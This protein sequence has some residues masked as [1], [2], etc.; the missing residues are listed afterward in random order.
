M[1]LLKKN[2]WLLFI[3][4][5]ISGF[6]LLASLS[7]IRWQELVDHYTQSQ[8]ASTQHWY[9]SFTSIIQQ[10]EGI[11]TLLGEE[12][13]VLQQTNPEE[14]RAELDNLMTLNLDIFSGFA[15]ISAEGDVIEVTSNLA[16]PTYPQLLEVAETKDSFEY[17]LMT[18]KMVLGRS[19]FAPRLVIPARKTIYDDNGD[20]LGVMTG[21]LKLDGNKGFFGAGHVLGDFNRITVLRNRDHYIQY[22]SSKKML[23]DFHKE[24]LSELA[25]GEL[26]SLFSRFAGGV[27]E[28]MTNAE[29]VSFIR[30]SGDERGKVR[31]VA[32]YNPRYEFWLIS[33]IEESFL[34]GQFLHIFAGYFLV[35]LIFQGGM[36]FLFRIIDR[37]QKEQRQLLEYEASHDSLTKLPN[38]NFL[39]SQFLQWQE[40]KT[41]FSLLFIDLDN[42][43]GINDS[44]GHSTGDRLLVNLSKRLSSIINKDDLLIRHGGDEF[45]LLTHDDN[46]IK[47]ENAITRKIYKT[48]EA[49]YVDKILF[50]PGA[51]I[52]IVRFPEHGTNLEEL[53]RSAD[54]AMYE[55]KKSRNQV[56]IFEVDMEQTFLQRARIEH[57][58]RGAYKRGEIYMNYQP[59]MDSHGNLW[60]VESLVRWNS[61]EMGMVA[62]DSFISVAEQIGIMGELGD[63]IIDESLKE[64]AHIQATTNKKF[65][66]SINVSIR[67]LIDPDFTTKFLG[68]IKKSGVENTRIVLEITE[69]LLIEDINRIGLILKTI[70][71]SGIKVS[72]DD[73]GTG[74]SSLSL[75]RN[76]SLDEIKIDKSFI[77]HI[78]SDETSLR[79]VKSI[80]AIGR[81]YE[82][83]ILAE[84]VETQEQLTCLIDCG[85][86]LIQGYYFSKPLS[87][88]HL[89]AYIEQ[90]DVSTNVTVPPKNS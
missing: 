89:L 40:N 17:T 38:R 52:G 5:L 78:T 11:I 57:F 79:M 80:I 71:A 77:D 13:F 10:Q 53:L 67:Q 39:I 87:A 8:K 25:Y 56:N 24:P 72:L 51:S 73:F 85:C 47:N 1:A 4:L 34:I 55:A 81:N 35:M 41:R 20:I 83:T 43:K 68:K 2:I 16:A 23:E 88:E 70:Q 18:D 21:A 90:K 15:L 22:A 69:S 82:A 29:G 32:I 63:F 7:V 26:M 61:P 54:I 75:L 19:Y 6:T 49:I 45:V 50:S 36:Y 14:V 66:L 28:A 9:S 37:T 86:D 3:V 84:G 74:Y 44:F 62:P 12:M 65:R 48:C 60:G 59:Q 76:L 58:I 42:F 31:G 64:I 27:K 30:D 46:I 33:E